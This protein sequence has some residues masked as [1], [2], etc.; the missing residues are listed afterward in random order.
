V[1]NNTFDFFKIEP[2]RLL[3]KSLTYLFP[4]EEIIP[5]KE[6]ISREN[7]AL[8][9]PFRLTYQNHIFEGTIHYQDQGLILEIEPISQTNL[10]VP[11]FY[12]LL[13][14]T[15]TK[16]QSVDNF[17]DFLKVTVKEIRRMTGYDR[18]MIYQFAPDES[19][20]VVAEDKIDEIESYLGLHYP[21]T[22]IPQLARQLYYRNWIR[23]IGNVHDPEI[24]II[25]EKNPLNHQSLDLS[26]SIL[27]TVSSVHIEYLQ[28]M[29]V[30]ATLSVSIINEE[31]LWGMIV[32]HHY[33]PKW[34]NRELR[35]A[36][37]FLGQF[38]SLE[39]FKKEQKELE[40][41]KIEVEKIQE[42]IHQH[43]ESEQQFIEAILYQEG[44][45]LF[46]LFQ[47]TGMAIC[48]QNYLTLSGETPSEIE[49]RNLLHW[50]TENNNQ[51]V[52]AT[53]CLSEDYPEATAYQTQA[54]GL[55]SISV[56]V[57]KAAYHLLWFRPEIIQTVTWGG[58]P[59]EPFIEDE[60]D[61][62][63][64]PRK[65]FELW[66]ET[67][68]GTSKTWKKVEIEAAQSLRNTLMLAVLGFSQIAL[69]I[70]AKKAESANKAKSEFLSNMSH[71]IRTPMN[72]ILGFSDLLKETITDRQGHHYLNSIIASG[73][74]LFDLI[75][76]IL[77]LSKIEA[78]KL[79]LHFEPV[80]IK[81]LVKE[82]KQ[83][84]QQKALEKDLFLRLEIRDNV[85]DVIIFDE[86]RL[87][88]ILFNIVGNAFKFTEIGGITIYLNSENYLDDSS[89]V[90]LILSIQD[91]GIGIHQQQKEHIF[92]AFQQADGQSTRKY[93][94]TGLGLTI[95][96]RLTEMLEGIVELESEPNQGSCF[97]FIFENVVIADS[98]ILETSSTV[99]DNNLNQF[100]PMTI[101][102]ADDVVSN[103]EV[104]EAY[105]KHTNHRLLLAN[106]G[107]EAIRIIE[108]KYQKIDLIL[109]DLKMPSYDGYQVAAV[110]KNNP[111][112]Q[113]IPIIILTATPFEQEIKSKL[114]NLNLWEGF[115]RKPFRRFEL[116][117]VLKRIF[118][119][120]L[121]SKDLT[122]EKTEPKI[123][124]IPTV[125]EPELI[126]KLE[127]EI[128]TNYP[129]IYQRMVH[130]DV[131][132]F[133]EQL[134]QW[135]RD[136]QCTPLENYANLL[137][138]YLE[139]FESDNLSI[140]LSQFPE[141]KKQLSVNS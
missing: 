15:M 26:Y 2:Q 79:D 78:G 24:K 7:L 99:E 93:G 128:Q 95:T 40:R 21:A 18:V 120:R 92:D 32:C 71:E 131:K 43:L 121:I 98:S 134:Q 100:L 114:D 111:L 46:N 31:K 41:Y 20:I 16:I 119:E 80:L 3:E 75:N 34:I 29:G 63:L 136:Y 84:F 67:V 127:Q 137:L 90:K 125:V 66:K 101:L 39:L 76:D 36:C 28:N 69:E 109:L 64:S 110:V 44:S 85:P 19:G 140:T 86:I 96:K 1:S 104:L 30:T 60:N 88:Q 59:N 25:P 37:E 35:Q 135:S 52:Y 51:G 81:Q 112:T 82:M 27:R 124:V 122:E 72:A 138:T 106:D 8:Y 65:S 91:T 54:S 17:V 53:H 57:N 70:T 74:T 33:S 141:L 38:I 132:K 49:V 83:I 129:I 97:K 68:R 87:R 22:D 107:G 116:V 14:P 10:G 11:S 102:A 6:A 103:L 62:Q 77:D 105:F 12:Q 56:V 4:K 45:S 55:L 130:G 50:L 118:P 61:H 89:K 139:N 126:E 58:N 133:A 123:N 73:K 113:S 117:A 115:L 47:A 23:I 48:L 94:G 108:Q 13:K 9:N 5:I 42:N